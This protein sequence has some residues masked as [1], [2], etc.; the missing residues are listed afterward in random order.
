MSRPIKVTNEQIITTAR[1][2]FLECGANIPAMNIADKLGISHTTIFNRF[3]SKEAL[4]IA[5][6]GPE[7]N[8]SWLDILETGPDERP[9]QEQLVEHCKVISHYF[10]DMVR[11]FSVLESAGI[12]TK[13]IF[14]RQKGESQPIKAFR[15]LA[16]WLKRAQI[17]GLITECD[18]DTLSITILGAL[19]NRAFTKYFCDTEK[20]NDI[21]DEYI[22]LFI[23]L[24]WNGIRK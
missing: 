23:A 18:I 3:G 20:S 14:A 8:I 24:L 10:Q 15:T 19:H 11:G 16:S 1:R 17:R 9:I 7:E 5:A 6:L 21:N 22:E 12:S 2:C 13:K 4:M